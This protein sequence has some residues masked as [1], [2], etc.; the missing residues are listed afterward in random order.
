MRPFKSAGMA[1]HGV[2]YD[3]SY[4]PQEAQ[5]YNAD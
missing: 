4:K 2:R 1:C 3:L 5:S